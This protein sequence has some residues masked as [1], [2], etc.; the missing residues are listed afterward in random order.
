MMFNNFCLLLFLLHHYIYMNVL[1]VTVQASVQNK[2]IESMIKSFE[3][4]ER[5]IEDF[6]DQLKETGDEYEQ[7]DEYIKC[8][9][10]RLEV[11][12]RLKLLTEIYLNKSK[13]LKD[14]FNSELL[15]I[16]NEVINFGDIGYLNSLID[17]RIINIYGLNRMSFENKYLSEIAKELS[18]QSKTLGTGTQNQSNLLEESTT[19][20]ISS[21][22]NEKTLS[23]KVKPSNKVNKR[24][25]LIKKQHNEV[26]AVQ[27]ETILNNTHSSITENSSTEVNRKNVL[28]K[29]Q[30]NEVNILQNERIKNY[31][32]YSIT[33]NSSFDGK[34]YLIYLVI[35]IL[36]AIFITGA[37][38]ILCTHSMFVHFNLK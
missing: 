16:E 28:I 6:T 38:Y 1:V 13:I 29:K 17:S 14:C 36:S 34:F 15:D 11:Q 4:A 18:H 9:N 31:T 22:M 35:I 25:I 19:T 37:V 30:L 26:N 12:N 27:H 33:E 3:D 8:S 10:E 2:Y 21:T 20:L 24:N 32:H 5:K 7:V 23:Q